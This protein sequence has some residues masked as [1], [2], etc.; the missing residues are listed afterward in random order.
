[1]I[2]TVAFATAFAQLPTD[3][4]WNN[5]YVKVVKHNRS[6]GILDTLSSITLTKGYPN[7]QL[8]SY[9]ASDSVDKCH[10]NIVLPQ[11]TESAD[12][13]ILC[14]TFAYATAGSDSVFTKNIGKVLLTSPSSGRKIFATAT[15]GAG[16][17]YVAPTATKAITTLGAGYIVRIHYVANSKTAGTY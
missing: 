15:T 14:S 17:V 12:F 13:N 9:A 1:M 6:T 11:F 5:R 4:Q 8:L 16:K 3:V 2:A 10:L 7:I